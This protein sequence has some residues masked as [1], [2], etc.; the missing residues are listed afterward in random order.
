MTRRGRAAHRAVLTAVQACAEPRGC[1]AV[2]TPGTSRPQLCAD[3]A[4]LCWGR[5]PRSC[6]RG[7]PP[8]APHGQHLCGG[9][10]PAVGMVM[11]WR[12]GWRTWA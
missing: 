1:G 8:R 2:R 3:T 10:T 5:P 12:W 4:A 6:P 9:H 7:P 11:G